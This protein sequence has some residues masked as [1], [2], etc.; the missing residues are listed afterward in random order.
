MCDVKEIQKDIFYAA[1]MLREYSNT[2]WKGYSDANVS[3]KDGIRDRMLIE[4]LK[5]NISPSDKKQKVYDYILNLIRKYKEYLTIG[6]SPTVRQCTT[7][8]TLINELSWLKDE[9]SIEITEKIF[10]EMKILFA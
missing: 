8:F 4:L 3:M 10:D 7:L 5:E 1:R 9:E 6:N 2:E